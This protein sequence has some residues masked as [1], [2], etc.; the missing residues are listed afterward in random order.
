MTSDS[1]E[2]P[3][4]A[5]SA[6]ELQAIKGLQREKLVR[7]LARLLYQEDEDRRRLEHQRDLDR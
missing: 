3:P 4:P 7:A 1:N 5:E 2:G 6:A